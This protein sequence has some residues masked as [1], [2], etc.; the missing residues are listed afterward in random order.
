M[1]A[2]AS[3]SAACRVAVAL[4][5]T[6][7][8]GSLQ[9]AVPADPSNNPG[10]F[11]PPSAPA[12]EPVA[13]GSNNTGGAAE[14]EAPAATPDVPVALRPVGLATFLDLPDTCGF[15]SLGAFTAV[16]TVVFDTDALTYGGQPGGVSLGGDAV[17]FFD[18]IDVP[19]GTIVQGIGNRRLILLAEGA[20][21]VAGTVHVNGANATPTAPS[22]QTMT[23]SPGGAG[24]GDGGAG[25][26]NSPGAGSIGEG[27]GG[28]GGGPQG[29]AG[30]GGAGFGG[31]GG[32]GGGGNGTPGA[33][34]PAYGDLL[35]LFQGGSGGGGAGTQVSGCDAAS[36]GG[37]GGALLLSSRTSLT[38]VAGAIVS[39]SGGNGALSDTGG[40][41]GGS[42][43]AVVLRAPAISHAGAV[44]AN[45]GVGGGGGCCGGG[46]SGAG[47][48]ILV[49]GAASGAG[50]YSVV[51]GGATGGGSGGGGAGGAGVALSIAYASPCLEGFCQLAT[52]GDWTAPAGTT[53][54]DTDWG[55]YG[56]IPGG[57]IFDGKMYFYFDNFVVPAGATVRGIGSRPLVIAA[58]DTVQIL[59]NLNVDGS[60]ATPT[61]P[62]CQTMT[63]SPGGAG[64]AD[65]GVG[66]LNSPGAGSAGEGPG[67]G[68]GGP[69]GT[70]GAGGAGFG[71]AGG[72]GGGG[73]GT[74]GAGGPAY[75]NLLAALEGGSGGGGAGTQFSGC[76]AASGGGGGGALLLMAGNTLTI[77]AAGV[78]S[79]NGGNGAL[80]DTGGSGGGG[81]GAVVLRAPA[82][83]HAGLVR[84]NGGSGG[85]GGC[86][87][88]GGSGG[89]GRILVRGAVTGAGS[90]T[91]AGGPATSGGT[92][93]GAAGSIGFSQT[94]ADL[95]FAVTKTDSTPTEIPGTAF[96]YTITVVNSTA[97]A[98][99]GVEVT[100][101]F[102]AILTGVTY[103]AVGTG[104]A[105]GFTGAGSGPIDDVVDLPAGSSVTYT[106]TG[107]LAASATGTLSNRACAGPNFALDVDTL[108]PQANLGVTKT[109]GVATAVP[110]TATTYTIAV[111]NAGPSDAPAAQVSDT[112]PAACTSVVWTCA[113]AG[114]G[115]CPANGSGNLA[116]TVNLPAGASVTFT[117]T[118]AIS[119]AA[120]GTL[121]NTASVAPGPGVTDPVSGND[122]ATDTDTLT[123]Q[124]NVAISKTDGVTTAVPGTN[125]TYTI[126]VSNAGPS[127]APAATV[128][129]TFPAACT[130][131]AWTCTGAGGGSCPANGSGNLGTAVNLPVGGSVTFSAVCPISPAATG[132]LVNTATVGAGPGVTDPAPGNNSSTDT[133][134]LTPQANVSIVKSDGVTTA[135][136]GTST[137][138][139]IA[140]ANAG[141]S[142]AP[143]APVAD[144][145]PAACTSVAWTCSGTGGGS[146]PA[147]G[148]GNLGTNV[149]LP[150]GG[151]VTF[152]ATC[153]IDPAATGTLVNTATVAPGAG[154]TDPVPGNNSATDT[155]TLA[156]QA[157][158]SVVKTVDPTALDNGETATFTIVV[159]NAGPSAAPGVLVE[160]YF[161]VA[162]Q[163]NLAW[164]C[165]AQGGATCAAAGTGDIVD[166]VDLPPGS[167]VTYTATCDVWSDLDAEIENTC[168]ATLPA[169]V[170][171]P[172]PGDNTG[173][174]TIAIN[175]LTI[176][177][178]PTLDPRAL[179]LLALL[180]GAAGWIAVRR[181]G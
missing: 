157:D 71:G 64:G 172:A 115:S 117:A 5:W 128:A 144:S 178:I 97:V 27:P 19:A 33:G 34:G 25:V 174:A 116:A 84:A 93:G 46:G 14:P 24:G 32:G 165:T 23:L 151:S 111:S 74:P 123:P 37:G 35:A 106:V 29:T 133:D 136:P 156:P 96:T 114:G 77:A 175:A 180:T 26:L 60:N 1:I 40:S 31:N 108:T 8:S 44:R 68:G 110:G 153:A 9:A 118:C 51:G 76:D 21:N 42:G 17:Y 152:S 22:C 177:E 13:A 141:P 147:N 107:T 83:G 120:V 49:I 45:A 158:V 179:A 124:A 43:G 126:V 176:E 47:G 69:Q 78:V 138:Y 62:S 3:R 169:G 36:G 90:F 81:G 20:I 53:I 70:A 38:I 66:V 122:S 89:G 112:F 18:S 143:A 41:G 154:V 181:Q 92:G 59:G 170:T 132:T 28:G 15:E 72:G 12:E 166:V 104:G 98:E 54:F 162:L 99:T 88:G 155:D 73:N 100:D 121:S 95:G 109:D 57:V 146:C 150:A 82:I 4:L 94:V 10:S 79:A 168:T 163:A 119:P 101:T 161:P 91:V 67:G 134:T 61:A 87:G 58:A 80:S 52:L 139:T 56:G 125:T 85:G 131:V 75:G 11:Q 48:R 137:T 160:D 142:N 135:V 164:T 6:G 39:A 86:C 149:N 63:L 30:A 130:S 173:T 140:V 127:H 129:D 145:F 167:S 113:G 7:L 2:S 55:T 103:S 50:T 16:G 148:S 102:A 159:A 65:G 105:S 171:D